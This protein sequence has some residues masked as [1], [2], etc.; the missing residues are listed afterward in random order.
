MPLFSMKASFN[1]NILQYPLFGASD[2][3]RRNHNRKKFGLV[4]S[5]SRTFAGAHQHLHEP[6][7]SFQIENDFFDRHEVGGTAPGV[8]AKEKVPSR[9]RPVVNLT[10]L[11]DQLAGSDFRRVLSLTTT[12][13]RQHF[14]FGAELFAVL[15]VPKPRL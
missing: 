8:T 12:T 14:A 13:S 1:C 2:A 5:C 7:L 3:G 10:Q 11:K 9:P 4:F 15:A 6:E